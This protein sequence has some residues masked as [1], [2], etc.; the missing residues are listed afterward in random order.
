MPDLAIP[1]SPAPL[2]DRADV[3][4][5]LCILCKLCADHGIP[6]ACITE[7]G[8]VDSVLIDLPQ[9]ALNPALTL[10]HRKL[11]VHPARPLNEQGERRGVDRT[12]CVCGCTTPKAADHG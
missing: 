2:D 8:P 4:G 3:G 5:G 11:A 12:W 10:L 7:P 6:H 9:V 1:A